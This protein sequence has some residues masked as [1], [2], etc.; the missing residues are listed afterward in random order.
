MVILDKNQPFFKGSTHTHTTFSDGRYTPKEVLK[1]Y[2]DRGYDFLAISDHN[3]FISNFDALIMELIVLC[4]CELT[5][6]LSERKLPIHINVIFKDEKTR[7]RYFMG[8]AGFK[9]H[10]HSYEELNEFLEPIEE[11]IITLNHPRTSYINYDDILKLTALTSIEVYNHGSCIRANNGVALSHYTY[12]LAKGCNLLAISADDFHAKEKV[13]YIKP[14]IELVDRHIGGF[15]SVQ[16]DDSTKNKI[17]SSIQNGRYY[18]SMGPEIRHL[19]IINGEIYMECSSVSYIRFYANK[20]LL[21]IERGDNLTSSSIDLAPI[22]FLV[23]GKGFI[24]KT[25]YLFIEI[26]DAEGKLAWTNNLVPILQK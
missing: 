23:E 17:F 20:D 11:A 15:I 14:S 25:Q 6:Y 5:F 8:E 22:D 1:I 9:Y 2:K 21:K 10:V 24:G 7:Y 13:K 19:E 12:A 3:R 18:A 26:E 4:G 16:A